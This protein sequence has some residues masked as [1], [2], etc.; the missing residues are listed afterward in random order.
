[1][2]PDILII[3]AGPAGLAVAGCLAQVGVAAQL[4]EKAPQL[5]AAWRAHYERLHLHT[6]KELSALPGLPFP[7]QAPRY[8]PRA[9]YVEYL[10]T[11]AARF[12]LVPSTGEEALTVA[13]ARG[14]GWST[15]TSRG[16]RLRSRAVVLATGANH[17]PRLPSFPGLESYRGRLLHS[18][19]YRNAVPFSGQRVLVVGMGNTGAEIALDLAENG[20]CVALAVRSPVNIV[21]RDVLGRPTQKTSILLGRLPPTLGD[22]MARMLRDLTVGNL[23]RLGLRTAPESPLRQLRVAGKTPVVD[24]GTLAAIRRGQIRVHPGIERFSEQGVHFADGSSAAFDGVIMA[25]G[26]QPDIA[27]LFPATEIPLDDRGLPAET[28]GQ[29]PRGGLCFV[30]FDTRQA[31]GLL[32]TIALQALEVARSLHASAAHRAP[33]AR[34]AAG[35]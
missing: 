21:R 24:I 22:A 33:A 28:V 20:A 25:T 18:H 9:A 11:Y 14:G 27:R 16:R 15:T 34:R 2:T 10:E 4:I 23:R 35:I 5:G 26:Y 17:V 29:G 7:R 13:P 30:G 31:G 8:V 1:M 32:R 6:V 3:G 19:A 12:G